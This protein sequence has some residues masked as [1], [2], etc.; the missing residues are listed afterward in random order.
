[1]T[2]TLLILV[3]A[4]CLLAGV[5]GC[6]M[7][8]MPGPP[9]AFLGLVVLHLTERV[10]FSNARLLAG[11]LLVVAVLALDAVIPALGAKRWGGTRW[12]VWGCLIGSLAGHLFFPP[13]GFI[14]G[15]FFGAVAG[16]LLGGKK[17]GGAFLAGV[18][19]F[20]GFLLGTVLKLS[21]CGLFAFWFVKGLV[22]PRYALDERYHNGGMYVGCDVR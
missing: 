20:M 15:S 5:V 1:M 3:G 12:G 18:G 16:E 2:D 14:L 11:L 13:A 8:A 10:Q 19:A 9:L 4:L 22:D 7:P 17:S 21:L 6:L